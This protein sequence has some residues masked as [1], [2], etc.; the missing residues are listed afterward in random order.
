MDGGI[1]LDQLAAGSMVVASQPAKASGGIE[2]GAHRVSC[3]WAAVLIF[4]GLVPVVWA[5]CVF[6]WGF[7][8]RLQ[9]RWEIQ[10][11]VA[12]YAL[13]TA[14]PPWTFV[15][16]NRLGYP[17]ATQLPFLTFKRIKQ[18]QFAGFFVAVFFVVAGLNHHWDDATYGAALF[19][20]VASYDLFTCYLGYWSVRAWRTDSFL[21]MYRQLAFACLDW[22]TD[23]TVALR[24]LVDGGLGHKLAGVV[25]FILSNVQ[26]CFL[27]VVL[28]GADSFP[29][30]YKW[31]LDPLK[32]DIVVFAGAVV[33]EL[34]AALITPLMYGDLV[35]ANPLFMW[36][37]F[38]LTMLGIAFNLSRLTWRWNKMKK[39][40][41]S[42]RG[43]HVPENTTVLHVAQK[44][45]REFTEQSMND[46]TP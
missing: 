19:V 38:G 12:M 32:A 7:P 26:M 18:S 43:S 33:C 11:C 36:V 34:P 9:N 41:A 42:G 44:G 15:A 27:A 14:V 2:L 16:M 21:S 31:M 39:A 40:A 20:A 1:T 46:Q 25:L 4:S 5:S 23:T 6:A 13:G 24:L 45:D 8:S 17:L 3:A 37:S 35:G 29:P 22:S 30:K 10:L 28:V